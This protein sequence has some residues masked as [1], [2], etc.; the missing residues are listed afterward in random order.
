MFG[1][2]H[3]RKA[4]DTLIQARVFVFIDY[5]IENV[6]KSI[7]NV[8]NIIRRRDDDKQ[9]WNEKEMKRFLISERSTQLC[10]RDFLADILNWIIFHSESNWKNPPI[11]GWNNVIMKRWK[12]KFN[13]V[14]IQCTK[15]SL[16]NN[17][18][19]WLDWSGF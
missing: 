1:I 6:I 2:S 3:E 14:P 17:K 7:L 5:D 8:S 10:A 12:N 15:L 13:F 18:V 11:F 16:L 19:C 4:Q 9:F